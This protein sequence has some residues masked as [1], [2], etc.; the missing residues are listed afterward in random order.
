MLP[1]NEAATD[2]VLWSCL[3][4]ELDLVF[5]LPA[6]VPNA[7]AVEAYAVVIR[8]RIEAR[9]ASTWCPPA[10]RAVAS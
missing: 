2:L 9:T 7:V 8:D 6:R 10:R 3:S 1:P 5:P 4:D